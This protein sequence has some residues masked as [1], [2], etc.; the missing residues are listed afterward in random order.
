MAVRTIRIG[1]S[2]DAVAYDD[3]DYDSAIETDAPIKAGAPTDPVDVVRLEDLEGLGISTESKASA[4][5]LA[6]LNARREV[7]RLKANMILEVQVFS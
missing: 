6:A 1:S 2:V 7:D 3:G 5:Y 4:A